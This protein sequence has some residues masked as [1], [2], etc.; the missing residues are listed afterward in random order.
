VLV[1]GATGRLGTVVDALVARGHVVRA[2]TRDLDAPAAKR[3]RGVG[4]ELVYGDFED[5]RSIAAAAAD[6]DALFATG[7]AHRAGPEGEER[8]GRNVADAAVAAGVAHI[9]YASGDGAAENS[10]LPLFRSKFRVEQHIRSLP[11]KYTILAPVYL[12]ENLF[13]PWNLAALSGG[14]FPSPI[15]VDVPMQQVA[16]VDLV[17]LAALVVDRPAEFVGRRVK[18]A[19]DQLSGA[20]GSRVVS[21]VIARELSAEQIPEDALPAALR[22]LFAWLASVGHDVDIATLHRAYPEV[23]WHSYPD[24]AR[25]ERA[26]LLALSTGEPAVGH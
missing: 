17:A 6:V 22:A 7:T 21:S 10:P 2:M 15:P 11:I 16:L 26:R 4:A 18:I 13:N 9:V 19:S 12:M 24:W 20:Q 5:L 23:G 3:L 25:S 8:H 1:A 14:A